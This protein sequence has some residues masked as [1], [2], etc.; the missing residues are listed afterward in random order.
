MS[1]NKMSMCYPY[2]MGVSCICDSRGRIYKCFPSLEAIQAAAGGGGGDGDGL[3]DDDGGGLLGGEAL[4]ARDGDLM[5]DDF[6]GLD[7]F[8]G[9]GGRNRSGLDERTEIILAATFLVL[10]ILAFIR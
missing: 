6:S 1:K 3:H 10:I 7:G 5:G 2:G 9:G 4:L 8:G